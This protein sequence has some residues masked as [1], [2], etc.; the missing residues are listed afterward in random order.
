MG[1]IIAAVVMSVKIVVDDDHRI[2][3]ITQRAPAHIIV[4]PVPM[5]PGRAPNAMRYPVPAQAQPPVPSAIVVNTPS[6]RFVGNPC[7]AR[8]RIPDPSP[9]IVGPPVAIRNVGSP[10]IA[11]RLFIDPASAASQLNFVIL[12]FR[13]KVSSADGALVE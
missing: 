7:P 3:V 9:I 5:N 1:R 13:G 4:P 12:E 11:I 2:S 8:K 6:P 10:D